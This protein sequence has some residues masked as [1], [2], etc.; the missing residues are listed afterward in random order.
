MVG[1][2][3]INLKF[4]KIDKIKMKVKN[5]VFIFFFQNLLLLDKFYVDDGFI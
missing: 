3:E 2:F 4:K 5:M 1:I